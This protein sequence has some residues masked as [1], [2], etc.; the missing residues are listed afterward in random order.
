[1][2]KKTKTAKKKASP[3]SPKTDWTPDEILALWSKASKK[4]LGAKKFKK[5]V[6]DEFEP[7]L[8]AKIA[9]TLGRRKFE[10]KDRK[11]TQELALALGLICNVITVKDEIDKDTF[12]KVFFLIKNSDKCPR[13]G[14]GGEWCD[15]K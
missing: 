1:M 15:I 6:V 11:Q 12:Q 7:Q 4:G 13:G 5:D 3:N 14:G 9:E 8:K 10:E 2:A